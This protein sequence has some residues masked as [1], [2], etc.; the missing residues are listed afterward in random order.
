MRWQFLLNA[1]MIERFEACWDDWEI[2]GMCTWVLK[3]SYA[4]M[5]SWSCACMFTCF[6]YNLQ[7]FDFPLM[8]KCS[9]VYLLKWSQAL[10]LT[11]FDVHVFRW[12]HAPM[13]ICF[14]DHMPFTCIHHS[15]M[16]GSF[17][18]YLLIYSNAFMIEC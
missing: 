7:L 16:I 17:D 8:I 11:F 14:N 2:W 5:L 4:C 9:Y 1:E 6:A 10:M 15:H 12:S 13:S 18:D 3:Y